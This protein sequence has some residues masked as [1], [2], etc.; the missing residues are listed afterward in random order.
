MFFLFLKEQEKIIFPARLPA[1]I[2]EFSPTN[3][4]RSPGK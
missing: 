1:T 3:F 2:Q 4:A